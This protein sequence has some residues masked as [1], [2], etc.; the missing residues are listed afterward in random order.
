[1]QLAA[2]VLLMPLLRFAAYT[3]AVTRNAFQWAV[4]P[5]KN[6]LA[7]WIW[8]VLC[9]GRNIR[10]VFNLIHSLHYIKIKHDIVHKTGSI[11]LSE[12]DRVAITGNM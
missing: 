10:N 9:T 7:L 1:M 12:K 8:I 11:L 2:A 6:Y 4:Q 3:A 5:P